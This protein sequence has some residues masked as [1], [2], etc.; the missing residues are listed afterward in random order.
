MIQC[1]G[2]NFNGWYKVIMK[3]LRPTYCKIHTTHICSAAYSFFKLFLHNYILC[4]ISYYTHRKSK[5][6]YTMQCLPS[7]ELTSESDSED[8]F[9]CAHTSTIACWT[10][11]VMRPGSQPLSTDFY[12]KV[13]L[14]TLNTASRCSTTY[15]AWS[16]YARWN[17]GSEIHRWNDIKKRATYHKQD[18][19]PTI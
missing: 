7:E 3:T 16:S 1:K 19:L 4:L 13:I 15:C 6:N 5:A 10:A 17:W 11:G 12:T 18:N 14:R 8:D 2:N 9:D